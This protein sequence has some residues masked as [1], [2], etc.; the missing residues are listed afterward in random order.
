L[1][2]HLPARARLPEILRAVRRGVDVEVRVPPHQRDHLVD[3]GPAAE[4]AD[5]AELGE[6]HGHLI[7]V[8]RMAEVVRAVVRVVHRRVDAHGD[9]ELRRLGVERVVASIA[10]RDAVDQRRDAEG[11]EALLADEPPQRHGAEAHT[12]PLRNEP[13]QLAHTGHAL[14]RVD[15]DARQTEEPIGIP[16]KQRG[17]LVV[18]DA[19][20]HRAH[21]AELA[22]LVDVGVQ[23]HLRTVV[24]AFAPRAK[25][26]A[27]VR[28]AVAG[29]L[30]G[31]PGLAVTGLGLTRLR[32]RDAALHVDDPYHLDL[33]SAAPATWSARRA[34]PA[35]PATPARG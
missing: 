19:E 29:R 7:Q 14:E 26:A 30:L 9:A 23:V 10:R 5:D 33:L 34:P 13:L 12:P 3:P 1:D 18:R 2:E 28:H 31:A 20:R 21:D 22:E 4:A 6:V 8:A 27:V 15:A 24:G 17:L 35:D 25:D 16:A 32:P 11:H